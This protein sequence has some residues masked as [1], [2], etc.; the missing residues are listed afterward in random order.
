M[1]INQQPE[2][3]ISLRQKPKS[4]DIENNVIWS[5][6]LSDG[7]TLYSDNEKPSAWIRLKKYLQETNLQIY[8]MQLQFRSH[9]IN[10]P[11]KAEGYYFANGIIASLKNSKECNIVGVLKNGIVECVWFSIPE[12]EPVKKVNKKIEDI[13]EPFIIRN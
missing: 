13:K 8:S 3:V 1:E 6:K 4:E 5:V 9:I 7:T 11:E 12:L 10:M 2:K